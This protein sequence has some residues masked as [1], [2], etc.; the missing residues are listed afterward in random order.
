MSL[1]KSDRA[2][3]SKLSAILRVADALDHM[4]QQRVR[5]FVLEAKEDAYILWVSEDIG[6]VAI[7]RNSLREKGDMFAEVFGAPPELKQKNMPN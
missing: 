1:P 6:D 2:I 7:E 5:N 4:H 3:V